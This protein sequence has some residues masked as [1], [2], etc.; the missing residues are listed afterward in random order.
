MTL[1][2][3]P[4]DFTM[5][6]F[7]GEAK[8]KVPDASYLVEVGH[9]QL[10]TTVDFKLH[11]IRSRPQ[12]CMLFLITF[13]TKAQ[14]ETSKTGMRYLGFFYNNT[15]INSNIIQIINTIYYMVS[16]INSHL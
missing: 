11:V 2:F 3:K 6:T 4:N 16:Y 15:I 9:G 10:L 1:A 5:N 13:K 14:G 8:C 7:A 12:F